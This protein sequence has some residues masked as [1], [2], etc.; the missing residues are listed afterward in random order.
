MRKED[1][2]RAWH[3]DACRAGRRRYKI[4]VSVPEA[5]HSSAG[6]CCSGWH[7]GTSQWSMQQRSRDAAA[8][9]TVAKRWCTQL[10]LLPHASQHA[11]A[12]MEP[13]SSAP[14]GPRHSRGW[15]QSSIAT[16]YSSALPSARMSLPY[17]HAAHSAVSNPSQAR[18][19]AA[20]PEAC[21]ATGSLL[22][23]QAA[24]GVVL[25][26]PVCCHAAAAAGPA[27]VDKSSCLMKSASAPLRLAAAASSRERTPTCGTSDDS[28]K[29][30]TRVD[31]PNLPLSLSFT[32]TL[33]D[34]Q[35]DYQS[36]QHTV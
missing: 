6:L 31:V 18:A 5:L 11:T 19:H 33:E 26:Q 32:H 2:A 17:L 23:R 12:H 1:G 24:S 28:A 35:N 36:Q 34:G 10:S 21:C 3:C 8:R 20:A 22:A 7:G 4:A 16:V 27:H 13:A 9:S 25:W 30:G 15:R 29:A 14:G